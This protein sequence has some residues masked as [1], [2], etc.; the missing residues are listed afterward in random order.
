MENE[1]KTFGWF[2][3]LRLQTVLTLLLLAINIPL[4]LGLVWFLMT[5]ASN[6]IESQ[7][8]EKLHLNSEALVSTLN[9]WMKLHQEMLQLI[10]SQPEIISQNPA[11]QKPFLQSIHQAYPHLF[12]VMTTDADGVNIARSDDGA[13]QDYN[14]RGWYRGA[15]AGNSFSTQSLISRTSGKPALNMAAAIR[16]SSGRFVGVGSIVSELDQL[17]L[18]V[19]ARRLGETGYAYIV[20]NEDQVVVH[21]DPAFSTE[22]RKLSD[23]PP[24]I[25]LRDGIDG[26]FRFT[27]ADGVVWQAHINRL[28]NG[29]GVITQQQEAELFKARRDYLMAAALVSAAALLLTSMLASMAI[30]RALRPVAE[31]TET[32]EAIAAGDLTRTAQVRGSDEIGVLAGAFNQ[33]T[34]RLHSQMGLLEQSVQERTRALRA[35]FQVSQRLA[36]ILNLDELTGRVVDEIRDAFDY[37]HVQIYLYD[38]TGEFLEMVGGTGE[39]GKQ[40]LGRG[41]R[42]RHG[43]GLVGRS[44]ANA[45][46]LYVPDTAQ[47]PAWLPN[48]LLP[49]TRSEA[50]VPLQA[51]DQVLGVLDVQLSQIDALSPGDLELLQSVANQVAIAVLNAGRYSQAQAQANMEAYASDITR[52]IQTAASVNAVLEIAVRELSETLNARQGDIQVTMKGTR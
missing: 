13:N 27:D 37:Y 20:D 2:H 50:A 47:E 49:E 34:A 32:A 22:L 35:S 4:L 52:K 24:V 30:Q 33:M 48:P 10:V 15:A 17:S 51:G 46:I 23:Y 9:A 28:S 36:S 41:H 40:M 29:W 14:D 45:E 21:P 25:A 1:E 16:D 38:E 44:A 8:F 12:L 39:A 6:Q 19:Q 26:D 11:Q 5:Q 7:A 42:L 3:S 18:E 43:R 31:L